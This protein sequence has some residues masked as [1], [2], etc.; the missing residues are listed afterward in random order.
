MFSEEISS[1][2]YQISFALWAGSIISVFFGK[3][4]LIAILALGER[5]K[6][7]IIA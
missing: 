7:A 5:G 1:P 3:L 2:R 6:K 4:T